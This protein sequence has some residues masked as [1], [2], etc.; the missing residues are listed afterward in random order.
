MSPTRVLAIVQAGGAGSRMD[1][2]TRERAKP[3]LPVVGTYQL[4][5]FPLSSLSNSGI[6]D[7][8]VSLQFH[9][10]SLEEQ[11][12]NGRPWDLDR[13]RGGLRLLM[14]EQG[15]GSADEDGFATGNADGLFRIRDQITEFDPA[16]VLVMS[17]DHVYRLDF[18]ELV[19]THLE[20]G[21]ECTVVTTEVDPAEAGDH[22]VIEVAGDRIG[23]MTFFLDTEALFPLFGLP[24]HPDDPYELVAPA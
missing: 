15:T 11:V 12:A 6:T 4:I 21:D 22:A 18:A 14:P 19:G 1:V 3:A 8:W 9:G 23:E 24:Q 10:A 20:R 2:L 5:D 16:V 17:A 13:T 7:V